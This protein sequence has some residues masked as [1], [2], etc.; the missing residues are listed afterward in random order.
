LNC[1]CLELLD[2]DQ[3]LLVK[4]PNLKV[5]KKIYF[6]TNYNSLNQLDKLINIFSQKEFPFFKD[7]NHA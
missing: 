3:D 7:I 6:I 1:I 5:G 4:Y 2:F